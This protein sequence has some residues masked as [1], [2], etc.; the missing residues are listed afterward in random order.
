MD[1]VNVVATVEM[2]KSF[3]LDELLDK[4]PNSERTIKWIKVKIPPY[5]QYTLFYSSGKFLITGVKSE[6]ELNERAHNIVSFIRESG[7]DNDIK[8]IN[9]HNRVYTDHIGF[10]VDLQKLI[11]ELQN[12]DADY[13]PESYHGLHFKDEHSRTYT[14]F[15]SGKFIIVGVKSLD[16]LEEH[17]KEF[18]DLIREKS[19]I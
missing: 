7:I 13:D 2:E 8:N 14:L 16:N 17:V 1:L 4:L 5:T 15:S 18:K 9:I 10:K 11:F 12:Y 6:Q 19:S 3:D